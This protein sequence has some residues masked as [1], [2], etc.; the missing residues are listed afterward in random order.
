[1][2]A[3]EGQSGERPWD[4]QPRESEEAHAAFCAWLGQAHRNVAALSR[5]LGLSPSLLWRWH[6]RH[7]WPER[8]L[9]FDAEMARRRE[10]DLRRHRNEVMERRQRRAEETDAAGRLLLRRG[11][12]PDPE[13]DDPQ[14][15]AEVA[16]RAGERY[17]RLATDIEDRLIAGSD[18]A[19]PATSIEEELWRTE[20]SALR[21]LIETAKGTA[22]QRGDGGEEKADDQATHPDKSG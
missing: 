5:E 9:A 11:L 10:A 21:R 17:L 8:A 20:E 3:G 13:S 12:Q 16:L 2:S 19:A 7:R 14:Q 22:E 4:R 6:K 15:V 18:P 1:M